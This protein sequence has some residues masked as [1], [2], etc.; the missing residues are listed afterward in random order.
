MTTWTQFCS[1]LPPPTPTWTFL[2]LNVDKNRHFLTTYHPFL[3]HVVIEPPHMSVCLIESINICSQI[4]VIVGHSGQKPVALCI[5]LVGG[6]QSDYETAVIK[7][8]HSQI[9]LSLMAGSST[10][11]RPELD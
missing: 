1:F 4:K 5:T 9:D 8:S 7:R 11:L 10:M 3:V 6:A 2:T